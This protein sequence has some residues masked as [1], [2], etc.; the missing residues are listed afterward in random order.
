MHRGYA[1]W[2][3]ENPATMYDQ[4]PSSI[5][6]E[7][8]KLAG[9]ADT[10]AARAAE[11]ARNGDAVGALH[12]AEVATAAEPAHR[13]AFEARLAALKSLRSKSRNVI[14]RRWLDYGIKAAE[15]APAGLD[16]RPKS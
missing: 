1:G 2:F 10:I 5:Y 4:P 13:T 9:G 15:K 6:P 12:M 11:M 3:D 16:G 8:V 7:L 14:E